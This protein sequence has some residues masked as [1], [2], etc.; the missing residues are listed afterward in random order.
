MRLLDCM[1][2]DSPRCCSMLLDAAAPSCVI[3]RHHVPSEEFE[4]SSDGPDRPLG[5]NVFLCDSLVSITEF[6]AGQSVPGLVVA[7]VSG[8][9]HC[10]G[11]SKARGGLGSELRL[12]FGGNGDDEDSGEHPN[13][14]DVGAPYRLPLHH[15]DVFSGTSKCSAP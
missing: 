14:L 11:P 5:D 7:R 13:G 10:P 3:L 12:A 1:P 2:I 8:E 6:S 4:A 15:G 9:P